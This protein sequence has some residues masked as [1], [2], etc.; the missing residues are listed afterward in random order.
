MNDGGKIL[1]EIHDP[2]VVFWEDEAKHPRGRGESQ[3]PDSE[4]DR[5]QVP[6]KATN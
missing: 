1:T 4:Q 5:N 2:Y 3:G 6:C